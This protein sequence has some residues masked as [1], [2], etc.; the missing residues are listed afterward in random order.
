MCPEHGES[1]VPIRTVAMPKVDAPKN[2]TKVCPKCGAKYAANV[3]YCGV[4]G[5]TL[6]LLN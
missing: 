1:L 4:D 5:E 6:A 2:V 3:V